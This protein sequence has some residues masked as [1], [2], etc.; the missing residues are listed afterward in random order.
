[1]DDRDRISELPEMVRDHA[2]REQPMPQEYEWVRER[3]N[4]HPALPIEVVNA[5]LT[6]LDDADRDIPALPN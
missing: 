3:R 4:R 5:I 6:E 1:M 2:H